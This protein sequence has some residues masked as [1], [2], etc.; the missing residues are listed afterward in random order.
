MSTN[1][2]NIDPGPLSKERV[3]EILERNGIHVEDLYS[4]KLILYVDL[5]DLA[6][7]ELEKVLGLFFVEFDQEAGKIIFDPGTDEYEVVEIV[8]LY[9][10]R[11]KRVEKPF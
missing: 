8:E 3:I 4:E 6:V 9:G 1:T 2:V 11:V 7:K 10:Y 5:D